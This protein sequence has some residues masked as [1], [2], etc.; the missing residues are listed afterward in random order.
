MTGQE[1]A[2]FDRPRAL[3]VQRLADAGEQVIYRLARKLLIWALAIGLA[4]ALPVWAVQALWEW[5][6]GW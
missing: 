5:M 2:T 4:I 1:G 3:P 6:A